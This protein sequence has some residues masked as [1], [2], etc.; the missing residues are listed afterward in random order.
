[1]VFCSST[2]ILLSAARLNSRVQVLG[3]IDELLLDE[4]AELLE[5]EDTTLLDVPEEL[6]AKDELLLELNELTLEEERDDML[7]L[8]LEILDE[9]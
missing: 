7:L 8:E 1:M 9:L 3:P 5:S 6:V 2:N 4:L